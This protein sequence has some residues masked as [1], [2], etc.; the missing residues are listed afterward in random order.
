[1]GRPQTPAPEPSAEPTEEVRRR[2]SADENRNSPFC[3]KTDDIIDLVSDFYDDMQD[4]RTPDPSNP[5]CTA[6]FNRT[7][8]AKSFYMEMKMLVAKGTNQ[9]SWTQST[10]MYF[11][12][13]AQNMTEKEHMKYLN[14]SCPFTYVTE[15]YL[16]FIN[17]IFHE[18]EN[19]PD[20]VTE[21]PESTNWVA[22]CAWAR[23]VDSKAK[24]LV[25]EGAMKKAKARQISRLP[26]LSAVKKQ[27]ERNYMRSKTEP[28][29]ALINETYHKMVRLPAND[30][31]SDAWMKRTDLAS[32]FHSKNKEILYG[33]KFSG[34]GK[35]SNRTMSS[36]W[37]SSSGWGSRN[38]SR[39][40]S[41]RKSSGSS[42]SG[43]WSSKR[44]EET[45]DRRHGGRGSW[46]RK[47]GSD[48]DHSRHMG[49]S[50]MGGSMGGG[51]M[52]GDMGKGHMGGSMGGSMMGG[53]MGGGNVHGNMGGG[54]MH[55][56]MGGGNM[57]GSMG[58]GNMHGNMGGGNMHGNMEGGNMHSGNMG[59]GNMMGGMPG[60][61]G[62]FNDDDLESIRRSGAKI[63]M[64]G[65]VNKPVDPPGMGMDH[66][67]FGNNQGRS[68]GRDH[69]NSH[70][71]S[72]GSSHGNSHGSS[73]GNSHGRS[74]GRSHGSSRGNS[75]GNNMGR[76]RGKG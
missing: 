64:I 27:H 50:H 47:G 68:Q 3:E 52:G 73:H 35:K 22:R 54:N 24:A 48:N 16:N 6:W 69:G 49:G 39:S 7:V 42:T 55:G 66:G 31:D 30:S 70:G 36:G 53:N 29:L 65:Q 28:L 45:E 63:T 17:T 14:E 60:N 38:S 23:N 41:W 33:N 46:G 19:L 1:M 2:Q 61:S 76:S 12:G 40:G 57:H 4:L 11:R 59:G 37:R 58:G 75:H 72:H 26:D 62:S 67:S 15:D 74:H 34:W 18:A 71:R 25:M 9:E 44:S 5:N 20:E 8:L 21:D 10:Y 13:Q 43:K 51:R 56:S 32:E